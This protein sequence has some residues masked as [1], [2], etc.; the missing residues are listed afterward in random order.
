MAR[1][2]IR[3]QL[4]LSFPRRISLLTSDPSYDRIGKSPISK[5][6]A[7]ARDSSRVLDFTFA[8]KSLSKPWRI[9][10]PHGHGACRIA[11][12]S[13][14]FLARNLAG[15]NLLHMHPTVA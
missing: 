10:L 14:R 5:E 11:A 3:I 6:F 8:S 7:D 4:L 1:I 15:H 13:N 2:V 12:A 9:D